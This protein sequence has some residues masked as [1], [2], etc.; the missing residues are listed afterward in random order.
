MHA[1]VT[2]GR[3]P[4]TTRMGAVGPSPNSPEKD[5]PGDPNAALRLLGGRDSEVARS[6][7]REPI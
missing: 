3:N 5:G 6:L 2:Q 4:A 7:L 1:A